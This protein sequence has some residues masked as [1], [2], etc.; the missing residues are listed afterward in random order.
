MTE[1]GPTP[2][3]A[4]RYCGNCATAAGAEGEAPGRGV[5]EG[6]PAGRDAEG[7]PAGRDAAGDPAGRDGEG[8]GDGFT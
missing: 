6:D 7:D 4:G 2:N 3:R 8:V 5:P 1:V